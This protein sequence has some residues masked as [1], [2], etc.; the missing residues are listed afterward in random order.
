[1]LD[2]DPA[3][4]QSCT[5]GCACA[6]QD[7]ASIGEPHK[8]T[9]TG[10][11]LICGLHLADPSSSPYKSEEDEARLPSL[12]AAQLAI[13]DRKSHTGNPGFAGVSGNFQSSERSQ[14][15]SIHLLHSALCC[16]ALHGAVFHSFHVSVYA[17]PLLMALPVLFPCSACPVPAPERP[18]GID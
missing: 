6:S 17:I 15:K 7:S 1:M 2:G 14:L 5:P 12:T 16:T 9:T 13:V 3:G 10:C 11:S 4:E 8:P 18:E